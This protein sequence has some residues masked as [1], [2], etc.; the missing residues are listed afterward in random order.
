MVTVLPTDCRIEL[1]LAL[2]ALMIAFAFESH[3]LPLPL[4]DFVLFASFP[5]SATEFIQVTFSFEPL[6]LPPP[7]ADVALADRADVFT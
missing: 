6:L 4:F 2:L 3:A 1:V 5:S 7:D